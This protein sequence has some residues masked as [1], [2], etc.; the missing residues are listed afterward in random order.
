MAHCSQTQSADMDIQL[1][2]ESPWAALDPYAKLVTALLPRASGM[3]AFDTRGELR[4]TSEDAIS[5]DLPP[6]IGKS[7][8]PCPGTAP[9]KPANAFFRR[10]A[11]PLYLFWLRDDAG[12]LVSVLAILWRTG[13][14]EPR[15]FSLVHS[16]VKPAL[17]VLRR[18]LLSRASIDSPAWCPDARVTGTSRF[19][20]PLGNGASGHGRH[21]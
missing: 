14:A 19:C 4:W 10:T 9:A 13:E 17:E 2:P 8:Q 16:L 1:A 11:A 7:L 6:I 3:A 18:E 12:E 21:R 5:A 15:A 20:S